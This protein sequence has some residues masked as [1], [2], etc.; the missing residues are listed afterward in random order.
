MVTGNTKRFA[1][2]G[3]HV[4]RLLSTQIHN[5]LFE[6]MR[7]D[8]VYFALSMTGE[9]MK[10]ALPVM[11]RNLIGFNITM[12]LKLT[13]LPYL[14]E[15]DEDARQ[16][17]A[18]NTVKVK[19]G[20]MTGYN[21]DVLGVGTTLDQHQVEMTGKPVLLLGAGGAAR[22]FGHEAMKRGA[23]LTIGCR[24]IQRAMP[25]QEELQKVYGRNVKTVQ[26]E[27]LKDEFDVIFQATPIGMKGE[28]VPLPDAMVKG[29]KFVFDAV[30]SKDYTPL[31][32][33]ARLAGVDAV[34]GYSMVFYQAME[35]QKIY[36]E[37]EIPQQ[38][39]QELFEE[40][41]KGFRSR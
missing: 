11:K 3:D 29:A 27:A 10:G 6:R 18:V 30:Y 20:R 24:S 12:P 26:M 25:F 35:A 34:D 8:A 14:D 39:Q 1:L 36:W 41:E 37:M 4:E 32:K 23:E 9:E 21:T 2:I 19:D 5:R 16:I 22:A 31:V 28:D 7:L 33:R 13:I 15:M 40:T 17:G 38:V